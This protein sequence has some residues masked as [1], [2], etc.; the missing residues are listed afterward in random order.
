MRLKI[1][2]FVLV[3]L[4]LFV[5]CGTKLNKAKARAIIED[6]LELTKEDPLEI[7]EIF[8]ESENIAIVKIRLYR[9]EQGECY[10]KMRKYVDIGWQIYEF[11]LSGV[12]WALATEELESIRSWIEYRREERE[13][14]KKEERVEQ[15]KEE[16][17]QVRAMKDIAVISR[18]IADYIV[19]NG[20]APKQD[21]IYNENSKFYK[22][23]SP[24]YVRILPVKDPWGNN[25]LVYI[26]TAG[27]GKYEITGCGSK[28]YVVVS[29]GQDREKEKWEFDATN[30][31]A[32]LFII[33]SKKDLNKDF[34]MWNRSWIRAPRIKEN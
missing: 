7:L 33:K 11:S 30:S 15:V 9:E 29:Y 32:G 12:E 21:G 26:G 4:L 25:Y 10:F 28:D 20:V 18:A 1:L 13:E 14:E 27:N 2:C 8:I 34:I 17:P 24:F 23:L 3:C 22:H 19:D 31:E 16:T 5:S 6:A